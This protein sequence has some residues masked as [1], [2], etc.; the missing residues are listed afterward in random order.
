MQLIS[1]NVGLP[2]P[3]E[4][5]IF[6]E[7]VSIG[8]RLRIGSAEFIVTQ[9]R[10][11]CFKLAVKFGRNDMVRRFQRSGRFGFYLAVAREGFVTAGDEIVVVAR[12]ADGPTVA[13]VVKLRQWR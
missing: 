4:T 6:K 9:P 8:D 5:A 3:V 10:T 12:N 1:T 7:D 13:E 11:P 2:R